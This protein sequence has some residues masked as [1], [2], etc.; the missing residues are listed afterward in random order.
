VRTFLAEITE[1]VRLNTGIALP[2]ARETAILVAVARAAP[3]LS[4]AEFMC[5]ASDP[6]RGRGLVDRLIDEVTV[7]ETTFVRDRGQ[8]DT[9]PWH[10]LLQS[11]RAA[12]ARAVRVW[13]AACASGEEA[14][15]LAL[16]ADRAFGAPQ[17]PVDVLGTDISG[18]ALEAAAAGRYRERAVRSL[19]PAFR[20]RYLDRQADGT[21]LVGQRL[22]ELVRFGRHNLA[23][24]PFPP[25]GEAAFDLVACRNVLIYFQQPAVGKIIASLEQSLRPGGMLMLGAADALHRTMAQPAIR[26]LP[27]QGPPRPDE[28]PPRPD[29]RPPRPD[30]RPPRP[31]ERPPRPDERPPRPDER[32]PRPDKR[33]LRRPLGRQPAP[34]RDDRLAAALDA[35]GAG[36]R[37]EAAR[38]VA[39]MLSADPLDA[40][41]HFVQ[42]LVT[43]EA[44]EPAQAA[45]ALRRALYADPAFSL[46]AF[47]LGRACDEMG[48]AAAARRA[49][50]RVLRT[51]DPYDHR[52]EPI[53][54]QV[55]VGDIAAACR[56]RL[57]GRP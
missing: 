40:D 14:Y 8:L 6:L 31:D 1:L 25:L 47:V 19:E 33:P 10:A 44:G 49:Y 53:L 11:A 13:S 7:Q 50:E 55:D 38:Q 48:D 26:A 12:G 16:L 37:A 9:V 17:A 34:S 56:A 29:E 54:Q 39:A 27:R 22:R 41:A 45:A 32:P 28:R 57:G 5:A 23:S 20:N 35:A 30:E 18:A 24:D 46:A 43:L 15:T 3:G 51:L 21:Y 42:G 2:A 36:D 52:H 4:P